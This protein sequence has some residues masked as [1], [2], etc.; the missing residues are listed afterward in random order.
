MKASEF[1]KIYDLYFD[2]IRKFIFYKSGNQ[3]LANDIAQSTF[4]KI[5]TSKI[6]VKQNNIKNLLYKIAN[7]KFIDHVRHS[8]VKYEYQQ[9]YKNSDPSGEEEQVDNSKKKKKLND[10]LKR[11]PEEQ[12]IVLIMNKMEGLTQAEI[13]DYLG[14]SIKTV[15]KR[16]SKAFVYLRNSLSEI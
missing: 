15:E 10:A 13:S 2:P 7:N 16:I 6:D 5:W 12:R 11:L 9:Y 14:I 8:K 3:D 1:K 4:M